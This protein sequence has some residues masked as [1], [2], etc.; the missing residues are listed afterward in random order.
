[1]GTLRRRLVLFGSVV[2]LG[3]LLSYP[4]WTFWD[5]HRLRQMCGEIR[6]GAPV[7]SIRR[8]VTKYGY[9]R[10]LINDQGVFDERTGSWNIPIPAPSTMG[11]M[12][13]FI[14]HNGSVVLATEVVGP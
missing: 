6:P 14:R 3:A 11:D 10:Y 4:A 9:E 13:C 2:L 1:M 7:A 5:M 8:T 12:A